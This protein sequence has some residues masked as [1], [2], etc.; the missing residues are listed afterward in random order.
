MLG[1]NAASWAAAGELVAGVSGAARETWSAS[2]VALV[3][4]T[5]GNAGNAGAQG[6]ARGASC[7]VVR[8]ACRAC[9]AVSR[10]AAALWS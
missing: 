3:K 8:L 2:G 7:C 1:L 5:L 4:A 10:E 6:S 9:R